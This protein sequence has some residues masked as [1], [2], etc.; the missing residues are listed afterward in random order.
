MYSTGT[1]I[2][3][4]YTVC[5]FLLWKTTKVAFET[6]TKHTK[7]LTV[8]A[9]DKNEHLFFTSPI[10]DRVV[11]K[12]RSTVLTLKPYSLLQCDANRHSTWRKNWRN[13]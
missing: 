3:D 2:H 1:H 7:Q 8:F 12:R 5:L 9:K 6:T 11:T 13:I 4:K 10:C